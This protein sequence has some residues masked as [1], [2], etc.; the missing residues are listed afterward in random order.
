MK[1]QYQLTSEDFQKLKHAVV[2]LESPTLTAKMTNLISELGSKI[3]PQSI[4]QPLQD[5]IVGIAD[6]ALHKVFWIASKTMENKQQSASP[7][8]HKA[9]A[10]AVGGVGG[11]FGVATILIELPISTTIMMRSILDIAR[12]EGFALDDPQTKIECITVFGLEGNISNDDDNAESGYF[13]TKAALS[14]LVDHAKKAAVE[15]VAAKLAQQVAEKQVAGGTSEL[16]EKALGDAIIKLIQTVAK[17][18]GIHLTDQAAAK[19][20]PMIGAALGATLNTM[21][22]DFYQ[23]MARGHFIVKKLE[24]KY[25]EEIIEKAYLNI[26]EEMKLQK[27]SKA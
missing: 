6:E 2:L 10:A 16:T 18:F 11:F 19:S 23:D 15:A 21:F 8:L 22:T 14:Q 12:E 20:I 24:K 4:S 9:A 17:R 3:I 27:L 25:S 26:Y 13:A 5:K 1:N 7:K